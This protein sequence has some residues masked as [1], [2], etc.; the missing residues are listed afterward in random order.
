MIFSAIKTQQ[1]ST[2]SKCRLRLEKQFNLKLGSEKMGRKAFSSF[3]KFQNHF[4]N[5]PELFSPESPI[6]WLIA[7]KFFW[8]TS[9]LILE[10][11]SFALL[12]LADILSICGVYVKCSSVFARK[13]FME[14]VGYNLFPL[15]LSSK[16]RS[17]WAFLQI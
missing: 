10:S 2:E 13:S 15:N 16:S 4:K 5:L 3:R 12:S 9:C 7:S 17:S 1:M 11:I 6:A 8:F 14:F